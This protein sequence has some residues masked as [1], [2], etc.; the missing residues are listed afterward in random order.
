MA[1]LIHDGET[2]AS[3]IYNFLT[4][5]LYTANAG[6]GAFKNGERLQVNE[7]R[8]SGNLLL[9]SFTSA[10]AIGQ[11]SGPIISGWLT[12][13]YGFDRACSILALFIIGSGVLY[14]PML[15]LKP[16]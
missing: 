5:V 3:V 7:K 2:V 14:A 4:D 8:T 10:M 12:Q 6:S 15:L 16:E 13:I 9:Y 1:A 11:F